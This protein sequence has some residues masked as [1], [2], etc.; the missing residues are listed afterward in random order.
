[1]T[2]KDVLLD[3]TEQ[4]RKAFQLLK[5]SLMEELILQYPDPMVQYGAIY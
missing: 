2:R 1:M 3:C 4:C 5:R